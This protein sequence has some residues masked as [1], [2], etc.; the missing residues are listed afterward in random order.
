MVVVFAVAS[1]ALADVSL[2]LGA[3]FP[4]WSKLSFTDAAYTSGV[5]LARDYAGQIGHLCG[6][7]E[8]FERSNTSSII[9]AEV[10]YEGF[11]PVGASERMQLEAVTQRVA[12]VS[13]RGLLDVLSVMVV[14]GSSTFLVLC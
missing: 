8:V 6:L 10:F 9:M 3:S 14:S 1:I 2:T 4:G 5:R 11:L 13:R 12:L 7:A